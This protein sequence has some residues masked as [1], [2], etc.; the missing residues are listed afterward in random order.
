VYEFSPNPGNGFSGFNSDGGTWKSGDAEY[1]A[2]L[3]K[4][5]SEF[6]EKKRIAMA[7]DFQ[8]MEAERQYQPSFPGTASGLLL[9]WPALRN[10]MVFR[11]AGVLG[12]LTGD[13]ALSRVNLWLDPAQPPNKA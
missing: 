1:T 2:L 11:D 5:R 10:V 13:P 9:A 4:A 12:G 3:K 8:R 7:R 6:D